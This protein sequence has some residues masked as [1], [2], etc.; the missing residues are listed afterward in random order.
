MYRYSAL[1]YKDVYD[2]GVDRHNSLLQPVYLISWTWLNALSCSD[3]PY[4]SSS[5]FPTEVHSLSR[6]TTWMI[7]PHAPRVIRG[8]A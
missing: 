4:T 6:D 2:I 3:F 5:R 7:D 8:K 1:V